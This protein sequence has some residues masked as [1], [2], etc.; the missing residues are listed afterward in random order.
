MGPR[1]PPPRHHTKSASGPSYLQLLEAAAAASARHG[2]WRSGLVWSVDQNRSVSRT[3]PAFPWLV[4]ASP[5][6]L[7]TRPACVW[8]GG[9]S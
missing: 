3:L 2:G 6:S 7:L 9:A 8:V 5:C 1:L 4:A